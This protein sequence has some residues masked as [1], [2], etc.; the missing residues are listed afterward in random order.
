M[1]AKDSTWAT[2]P[3]QPQARAKVEQHVE[4][5]LDEALADTFPASDP[6]SGLTADRSKPR[7][8]KRP[9]D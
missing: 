4:D 2:T 8:V 1:R 3:P 5:L 7:R 6:V 9:R